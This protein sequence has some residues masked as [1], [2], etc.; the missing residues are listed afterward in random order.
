[1]SSVARVR[2]VKIAFVLEMNA[3]QLARWDL[4]HNK[5]AKRNDAR[6]RANVLSIPKRFWPTSTDIT[7]SIITFDAV[8]SKP[9]ISDKISFHPT[10]RDEGD[11]IIFIERSLSSPS[12][13]FDISANFNH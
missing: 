9:R 1:M 6:V 3:E 7:V 5:R 13:H 10:T 12:N 2:S 4:R 8:K 11:I